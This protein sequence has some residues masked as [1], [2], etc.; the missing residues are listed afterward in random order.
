MLVYSTKID[1]SI[2][3]GMLRHNIKWSYCYIAIHDFMTFECANAT[4]PAQGLNVH[5]G[6][7]RS[8]T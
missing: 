8:D 5:F 4:F 1:V 2:V 3:A 6:M 7:N